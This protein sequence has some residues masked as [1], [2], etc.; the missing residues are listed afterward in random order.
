MRASAFAILAVAAATVSPALAMPITSPDLPYS[1]H[2][3]GGLRASDE[4]SEGSGAINWGGVWHNGVGLVKSLAEREDME[5]ES[6]FMA[7]TVNWAG[8]EQDAPAVLHSGVK[9]W[10]D[11]AGERSGAP[12]RHRTGKTTGGGS[13][14]GAHSGAHSGGRG[15]GKREDDVERE[16]AR[17][18]VNWHALGHDANSAFHTGVKI[19]HDIKG[20]RDEELARRKV[21]WEGLEQDAPAVL[22]AGVRVAHDFG[23]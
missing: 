12:A 18:K 3:R 14:R 13:G 16:L 21:N 10:H 19:Y 2:L 4:A 9:V 23:A 7:R 17:R 6:A 20:K 11:I 8:L 15:H 22:H 1:T 5:P